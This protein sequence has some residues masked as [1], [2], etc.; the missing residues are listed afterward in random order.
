[1]FPLPAKSTTPSDGSRIAAIRSVFGVLGRE[2]WVWPSLPPAER[3]PCGAAQLETRVVA[4]M[5]AISQRLSPKVCTTTPPRALSET[6]V[7]PS[8]IQNYAQRGDR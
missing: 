4:I 6:P 3:G 7:W 2:L 5:H 8:L 1:M